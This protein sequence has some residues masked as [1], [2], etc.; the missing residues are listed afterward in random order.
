[1]A[2]KIPSASINITSAL[3]SILTQ[4]DVKRSV[5]DQNQLINSKIRVTGGA[6]AAA[7]NA[8]SPIDHVAISYAGSTFRVS[9]SDIISAITDTLRISMTWGIRANDYVNNADS[10]K[11][12]GFNK[13]LKDLAHTLDVIRV[14]STFA[15]SLA[16]IQQAPTDRARIGSSKTLASSYQASDLAARGFSKALQS[17]VNQLSDKASPQLT[18]AIKDFVIPLD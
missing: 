11:S 1:M 6:F 17:S 2:K 16:S 4:S 10:I 8:L 5:V 12:F 13:S 14:T 9:A 3:R 18:K 15:R 7:S